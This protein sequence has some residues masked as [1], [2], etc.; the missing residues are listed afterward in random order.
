MIGR[1]EKIAVMRVL[2]RKVLTSATEPGGTEVRSFEKALKTYLGCKHV[3]AVNSGTSALYASLLVLGIG[4]GDEV[5][6][7]SF[8]FVATANAVLLTGAKPVFVDISENSYSMSPDD[9]QKKIS[10]D[11]AAIIPVHLYGYPAD[12]RSIR[13]VAIKNGLPIIEDAAQS[14]GAQYEGKHTG[15]LGELGCFSFHASKVIMSG[16]GGAIATDRN[17]LYD[18]LRRIR[19]HGI[20]RDGDPSTFGTNLRMGEIEAAILNVQLNR[21]TSF[22]DKRKRNAKEMSRL[23]SQKGGVVLPS[24]LKGAS[25]NW[26]LYTVSLDKGRDRVLAKLNRMQI[27]VRVYY[28]IPIHNSSLYQGL[29]YRGESLTMTERASKRVLSLPI[30]PGMTLGQIRRIARLLVTEVQ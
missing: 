28:R 20:G 15:T 7:P 13:S 29:G 18:K 10:P 27:D 30:H 22:L 6:V 24:S 25:S 2:G 19:T 26:Y 3:I 23:L 8:S 4:P 11:T 17:E 16:E 1:D 21:L 12:M 14:L 9:L 5:A